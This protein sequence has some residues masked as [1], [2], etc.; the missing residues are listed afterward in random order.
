MYLRSFSK[1]GT[2]KALER[3][4][5]EIKDL[6]VTVIWL[7]PIHPVGELNRKGNLGSPYSIQNYYATNPEFGTIEDFKSLVK[8][9]HAHGMKIILDLVVNHTSWDTEIILDHPEWY[10]TNRNGEIVAPNADWRDVADFN[11]DRHELRKYIMEMME[12]WVR[13][14]GVDGFRCDVAEMVPTDFWERA[15]KELDQ[16]KQVMLLSEGTLPEHHLSAFDLTYSWNVYDVL[17]KVIHGTTPV[18]VF[19]EIL[20][21][22]SLQYPRGSLRMRFNTNHDKNA[23]DE[24]AVKKFSPQGAK[25]T[26]LLTFTFPGVPL[27][28]NG[29][30][31]GNE[32]A[33]SLFEKTEIDW[34]QNPTVR[35]FFKQ[36]GTLR[37]SQVSLRRG[38][39]TPLPNSDNQKV[40]SFLRRSGDD[41]VIVVINFS[42]QP[43]EVS[44]SI[45]E[46]VPN[47]LKE[48]F[49]GSNAETAGRK[50]TL[51]LEGLD[52][53]VFLKN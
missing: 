41:P 43:K 12:Y 45:P 22:E 42:R 20:R 19:D 16:I 9:T 30:E 8:A 10:T 48:Y 39:Y 50:L 1:E 37:S 46:S 34:Q 26:A 6:G 4:L 38:D 27:I 40:F 28:Y 13:D 18:K 5:H 2:F 25:A 44:V 29:E 47:R 21:N 53:K 49:T 51:H 52:Y 17:G 3:R 14:V 33:L 31:V 11:Y 36:L 7:M 15:R 24:P 35:Q 32:K 23:W